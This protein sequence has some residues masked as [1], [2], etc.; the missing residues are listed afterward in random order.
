V[1]VGVILAFVLLTPRAWFRD[2]PRIPSSSQIAL[3]PSHGG[4]AFWID[5]EL[6][7]PIPESERLTKLSDMLKNR[8]GKTLPI[9]RLE[10]I[11]DSEKDVK[12]YMAFVKK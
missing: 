12:G 7:S 10:P 2:Q 8:F 6:V 5:P 11:Y 3:V 9:T 4:E 1:I